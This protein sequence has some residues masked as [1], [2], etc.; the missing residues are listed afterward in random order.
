[1]KHI[2]E[3][4]KII[5]WHGSQKW[6]GNAEIRPSKIERQEHGPGIYVTNNIDTAKKYSRGAG[7]ILIFEME[8]PRLLTLRDTVNIT[9]AEYFIKNLYRAKNKS[10]TISD[11]N[12]SL[13]NEDQISIVSV[14]NISG[15]NGTTSGTN[16]ANL[17]EW[18][19]DKGFDANIVNGYNGNEQWMVIFNP[20]IIKKSYLHD[21]KDDLF[22]MGSFTKQIEA[23][24][25][26]K[27]IILKEERKKEFKIK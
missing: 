14:M 23:I 4:G 10:K 16:T 13:R 25:F 19:V 27:D 11:L 8:V 6:N 20:S 2:H 5:A 12:N 22:Y 1:M 7:K 26:Q 18:I 21:K 24:G 17:T 9:E 15:L 3:E